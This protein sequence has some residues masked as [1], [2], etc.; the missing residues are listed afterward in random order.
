[1]SSFGHCDEAYELL[2]QLRKEH[3]KE[4]LMPNVVSWSAVIDRL[5]DCGHSSES[6][7]LFRRLRMVDINKIT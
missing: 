6:V 7:E 4:E 5:L 3:P 2:S 1:M